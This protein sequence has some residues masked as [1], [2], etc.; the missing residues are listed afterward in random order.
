MFHINYFYIY[1]SILLFLL[2]FCILL[3]RYV[4]ILKLKFTIFS[5]YDISHINIT[6]KFN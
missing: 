5:L 4:I 6:S 2:S 3:S 1:D